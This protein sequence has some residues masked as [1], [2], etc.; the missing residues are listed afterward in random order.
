MYRSMARTILIVE[1]D[2]VGRHVLHTFLRQKNY[3]TILVGDVTAAI[4]ETRAR[5]PDAIVLDLG[6]PAGGG[7]TFL[8]RIRMFPALA[9]IPVIIVS[10]SD[11]T[12]NEQRGRDLGA[13][14]YLQKPATNEAILAEIE[15]LIG[16]A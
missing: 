3:E 14:A 12:A 11:A 9:V 15:K 5:K 2:P 1:D 16:A 6:L 8:E 10:G 13:A 7:F 4:S